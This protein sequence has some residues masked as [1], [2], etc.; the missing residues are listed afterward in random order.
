MEVELIFKIAAI[1]IVVAVVNMVLS[2]LGR[3]EYATL[4]TLAG[5]IIVLLVLLSKISDLFATISTVF[6]L[7]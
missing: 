3:D 2:K 4:T 6:E 1:G 5:V 7:K